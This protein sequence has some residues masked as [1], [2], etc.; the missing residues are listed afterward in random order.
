MQ[1]SYDEIEEPSHYL[2]SKGIDV[3]TFF[4]GQFTKEQR[5][6]GYAKDVLKYV[7]RA[8]KKPGVPALKDYLKARQYLDKLIELEQEEA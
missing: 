7:T 6:G 5:R 8:G 3:W 4:D 2:G 1:P